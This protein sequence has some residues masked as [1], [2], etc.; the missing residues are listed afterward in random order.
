MR[1]FH[2][3]ETDGLKPE[4]RTQTPDGL[5]PERRTQ[6]MTLPSLLST[7]DELAFLSWLS[8]YELAERRELRVVDEHAARLAFL[9]GMKRGE[10]FVDPLENE[11]L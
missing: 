3:T 5:K 11:E 7:A 10:G 8:S 1:C 9:A 6:T 4:L 2:F